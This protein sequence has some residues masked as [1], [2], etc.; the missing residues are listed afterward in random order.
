MSFGKREEQAANKL[1]DYQYP[2]VFK[3]L[4]ESINTPNYYARIALLFATLEAM[5]GE[6]EKTSCDCP[7]GKKYKTYDKDKMKEILSDNKLFNDVFGPEGLRH[8]FLHG[9][10]FDFEL[11]EDYFSKIYQAIIQYFNKTYSFNIIE[12]AV[13]VPRGFNSKTRLLLFLKT[14]KEIGLKEVIRIFT[15]DT[16]HIGY[17]KEGFEVIKIIQNY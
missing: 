5:S 9:S 2:Q 7:K 4:Q 15:E 11:G 17:E 13:S 3:F 6:V 12:K 10:L 16:Y 14:T 8:K 1:K